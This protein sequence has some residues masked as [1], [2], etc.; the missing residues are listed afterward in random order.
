MFLSPVN[1][2]ISRHGSVRNGGRQSPLY[3]AQSDPHRKKPLLVLLLQ[4]L[5]QHSGVADMLW[6]SWRMRGVQGLGFRV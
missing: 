3:Q 2:D 6:H 5:G 4:T 1:K